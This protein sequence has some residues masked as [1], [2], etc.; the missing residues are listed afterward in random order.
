MLLSRLD[1]ALTRHRPHSN[2]EEVQASIVGYRLSEE[3]RWR[4][5]SSMAGMPNI[6]SLTWRQ[7]ALSLGLTP[8]P[9]RLP[10]GHPATCTLEETNHDL[11]AVD[12]SGAAR[13]PLSVGRWHEVDPTG[14]GDDGADA[15]DGPVPAIHRRGR[16]TRRARARPPRAPAPAAGPDT[17][18]LTHR[19]PSR[20]YWVPSSL[21]RIVSRL[22]RDRGDYGRSISSKVGLGLAHPAG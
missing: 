9:A 15:V 1:C 8:G 14:R 2:C 6:F 12:R 18:S 21:D 5:V 20:R 7:K 11:R 16:G 4:M 19:F 22:Y 17:A 3:E 10:R 13:A